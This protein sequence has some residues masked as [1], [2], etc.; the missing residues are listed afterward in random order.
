M[1]EIVITGNEEFDA[2]LDEAFHTLEGI[3]IADGDLADVEQD[4]VNV[5]D[6]LT[7]ALRYVRLQQGNDDDE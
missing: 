1:V 7:D 5:I 6:Q 3:D 4:L 2:V